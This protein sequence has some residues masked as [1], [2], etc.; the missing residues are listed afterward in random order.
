[1]ISISSTTTLETVD[2]A[3]VVVPAGAYP[4]DI[5]ITISEVKNP[6]KSSK[7]YLSLPYEFGP[8]GIEF[9]QPVTILIP[10]ED[11]SSNYSVSVY[12]YNLLTAAPSQQG[13]TNIETIGTSPTLYLRF[14]TTHFTQFFVGGSSSGG[15][16]GGSGGGGGGGC[17]MSAN[18]QA[19]IV[20]LL[21]PY[22]GLT[23]AMVVLKLKDR[24]KKKARNIT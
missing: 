11:P 24:R 4:C 2:G 3:S 15:S 16:I 17:S 6:P 5:K 1:N 19:S 21:L 20:E 10:Y 22:I 12:W 23:V 8:S 13:I 9:D 7:E 14:K 18:S